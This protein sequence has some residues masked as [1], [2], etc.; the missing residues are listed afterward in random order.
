MRVV[1]G[2][3]ANLGERLTTL[4][5]A[6]ARVAEHGDVRRRSHIYETAP[7]GPE[8]PDFLNAAISVECTMPPLDLLDALRS[9][10]A[11]FGRDRAKELRWGPRPLDLDVLWIE[12]RVVNE[13]RLVVPHPRLHERAFA[14]QPLLDVEPEA[15]D[16]RTGGVYV[17]P[18]S[19]DLRRLDVT[20]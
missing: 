12:G 11:S 17:V 14:V 1:I 20:L 8:Q 5:G 15:L 16:P 4:R 2:L 13:E 19:Q 3:G 6:V 9:I 10:E 18:S 7:I